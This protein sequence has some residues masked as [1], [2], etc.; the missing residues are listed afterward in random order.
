MD[1][2]LVVTLNR[3][4]VVDGLA[5]QV[6]HPTQARIAY[7]HGD[8]SAGIGGFHAPLQA[9]GGGHGDT[10]HHV[11]TDVLGH[12]CHDDPV[13]QRDFDGAEQLGKLIVREANVKNRAHNLD[14]CSYMFGHWIQLLVLEW[15]SGSLRNLPQFR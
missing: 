4:L 7:G 10:A 14:H 8:G 13:T 15:C 5:Q 6:K 1:G 9:V 3:L 11:V 2:P 12:L